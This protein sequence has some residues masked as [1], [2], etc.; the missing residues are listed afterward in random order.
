MA[1]RSDTNSTTSTPDVNHGDSTINKVATVTFDTNTAY[2]VRPDLVSTADLQYVGE[3]LG[4]IVYNTDTNQMLYWNGTEWR[5]AQGSVPTNVS[6][7]VNDAGYLTSETDSQTLNFDDSTREL[8]ISNGNTVVIPDTTYTNVSEFVNDAGYLTSETDSQ[9]LSVSGTELSI[10]NGNTVTLQ[11]TQ[12]SNLSE[13]N[14]D[15]GYITSYTDTQL[16][17]EQVQDIVGAMFSGNVENN[18]TVYYDDTTGVINFDAVDTNTQRTDAEIQAIIDQNTAGFL[19]VE[20]DSQ[21]LSFSNGELSISNGN[22]VTIPDTQ[23]SNVSEFTND[24][25]YITSADVPTNVSELTNDAGYITSYVD[26]QR[27]DAEIQAIIDANSAGF[28]TDGNTNWNNEYGFIT[29]ADVPTNVSELANDAGYITSYTDTQRSDEEIRDVA[30]AQWIDGTNTTVVVD[31]ANNTIKINATDTN[32]QLTD[33]QVKDIIAT[34]GYLT[35]ET[36]SQTLSIVGDQLTISNGNTVTIPDNDTTYSNLSEF[37][38]DVG[39]ITSASVPTNVSAFTND[40]GYLTSYTDTQRTDAEIEAIVE[41]YN[42]NTSYTHQQPTASA[43][44]TITH[45]MGRFPSISVVDSAGTIVNG[46]ENYTSNNEL[47]ITF[48]AAFSGT[49]YLN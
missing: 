41:S 24:A 4:R 15:V 10:S 43:T 19:T 13:F 39:Y 18:I 8:E 33:Q 3:E 2:A 30:N 35:V 37:T 14:N 48:N 27:T 32:T 42:Y 46:V 23:Y 17:N 11:D 28:I 5:E 36:D 21:T 6:A 22:T 16:T 49:A 44:W 40:A 38:N 31:D 29:S 45:N 25:G 26:T 34:E 20:T 12:Y 7:F 1:R 9:T 47:T